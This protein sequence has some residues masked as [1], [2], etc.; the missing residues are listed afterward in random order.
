MSR[1]VVLRPCRGVIRQLH[2]RQPS[3]ASSRR[4]RSRDEMLAHCSRNTSFSYLGIRAFVITTSHKAKGISQLDPLITLATPSELRVVKA[5][6]EVPVLNYT[7]LFSPSRS[8]AAR[9]PT[10]GLHRWCVFPLPGPGLGQSG[11]GASL[12]DGTT[13]PQ[14]IGY[15]ADGLPGRH[16]ASRRYGGTQCSHG[17][18]AESPGAG[19]PG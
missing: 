4:G 19:L 7:R 3:P 12:G 10:H 18:P 2:P 8:Q 14:S 15:S 1:R 13:R 9:P 5:R 6:A 11:D 17:A 16:S